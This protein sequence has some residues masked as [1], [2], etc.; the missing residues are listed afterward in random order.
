M[1]YRRSVWLTLLLLLTLLM[2]GWVGLAEPPSNRP[3]QSFKVADPR[4]GFLA[5]NQVGAENF[6]IPLSGDITVSKGERFRLYSEYEGVFFPKAVGSA[7]FELMVSLVRA[8]GSRERLGRDQATVAGIGPRRRSGTLTVDVALN[9]TGV[10][11]LAISSRITAHVVTA[12]RRISDEDEILARVTVQQGRSPDS[13]RISAVESAA[14]DVS[15]ALPGASESLPGTLPTLPARRTPTPVPEPPHPAPTDKELLVASPR[16]HFTSTVKAAENFDQGNGQSLVVRQG[17]TLTLKSAYEFVWFQGAEGRAQSELSVT[18]RTASSSVISPTIGEAAR[19]ELTGTGPARE[20]GVLRVPVTF[21]APGRYLLAARVRT[22]VSPPEAL[23][24]VVGDEDIV[25][26]MVTVVGELHTG[27]ITGTVTADG[28]GMPLEGV[29]VQVF[30]AL[31]GRPRATVRTA[32]DG[33]YTATGLAPGRY[34]VWANPVNQNYLPEWYDNAPTRAEADPVTVVAGETTGEIN[35]ALT[36]GG[37]ISGR[38]VEETGDTVTT[39]VPI[40]NVLVSVGFYEGNTVLARTRTLEDGSYRLE[41]LPQGTYWVHAGDAARA[42][43]EEYY[44]NKLTRREAD[45]V[46]VTVGAETGGIDF[47]LRYG[48]GISGRVVGISAGSEM[49]SAFKVTAYDWDTGQAVRTVDVAPR[50]NYFIPGLPEGSYRVYAFDQAGRFIAEYYDNVTDPAKATPVVVRRQAVTEHIDFELAPAGVALVEV[51]PLVSQ[52]NPGDTFSVTVEAS[53]VTDLGSFEFRLAFDPAIIQ[54]Q[55]AELG[56]FLGSTGRQVTAVGPAID[57][58]AGTLIYGAFSLGEE[59]GPGGSGTLAII[60]FTAAL[61]GESPLNLTNVRLVN[62]QAGL[63]ATRSQGAHVK[64]GGEC[65]AGDLD[66]DCDVDIADVMQVARRWGARR[67]DPEYEPRFDLDH[68]GDIDIVDVALV[69]SAWGNTCPEAVAKRLVTQKAALKARALSTG[70]RLEPAT[71]TTAVGQPITLHVWIDEALDL[72]SFEFSLT[73]DATRLALSAGGISLGD[74]IGST[75]R[76]ATA[77]SPQIT[78]ENGTGTLRYGAY[79]LGATPPGPSG[80]GIL[81]EITF[82]PLA[83]GSAEVT[84]TAA[85]VTNTTGESQSGLALRGATLTIVPGATLSLPYVLR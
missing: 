76:S 60:T 39:T 27:A 32:E 57:N 4:A 25:S 36:P 18:V 26:I 75:G 51:R 80:S 68:D 12:A 42:L 69:A 3:V 53:R 77:I 30:E 81:A 15:L 28:S 55:G 17:Y 16:G 49:P 35:F 20:A 37:A 13:D 47:A 10:Y 44:D 6:M 84:F 24:T 82:M 7:T 72:G 40:S 66:C 22:Q 64:V 8:D 61:S 59:P 29:S 23:Q 52:V 62:T 70:L 67:G 63:I 1:S 14:P 41:K 78:I 38:V 71:A 74:F 56:D 54:A 21:H 11:T 45:P 50:G 48:G 58:T 79:T 73:Y 83:A 46:T 9:S 31:T 19:V 5:L 43:I 65:I 33:S 34:L 85:Q 2:T